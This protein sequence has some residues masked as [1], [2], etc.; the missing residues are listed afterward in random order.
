[1]GLHWAQGVPL[2]QDWETEGMSEGPRGDAGMS[3]EWWRRFKNR[4]PRA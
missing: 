4:L 2:G 3:R 1:M